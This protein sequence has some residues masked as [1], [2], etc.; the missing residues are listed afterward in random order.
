[1]SFN[2]NSQRN[3][4][5]FLNNSKNFLNNSKISSKKMSLIEDSKLS[6]FSKKLSIAEI[7]SF[8]NSEELLKQKFKENLH[9]IWRFLMKFQKMSDFSSKNKFSQKNEISEK[10]EA[11]IRNNRKDSIPNLLIED[12]EELLEAKYEKKQD[13][14]IAFLWRNSWR[15]WTLL[16]QKSNRIWKSAANYRFFLIFYRFFYL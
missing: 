9:N 1:M 12:E 14:L 16:L 3:F 2:D 10:N 15:K 7:S 4:E 6:S 11:Y 8:L 13:N 5:N